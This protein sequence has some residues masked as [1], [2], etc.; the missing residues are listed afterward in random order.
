MGIGQ[1]EHGLY[2]LKPKEQEDPRQLLDLSHIHSIPFLNTI[3]S[4]QNGNNNIAKNKNSP[5]NLDDTSL[6]HKRLGHA[7]LRV[8]KKKG[9]LNNAQL[10]EHVYTV[11]P[12]AKQT[13]ILFSLSNACSIQ[14]FDHIHADVW[15]LHRVST[16]NGRRYFMT[17]VDDY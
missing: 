14:S 4:E 16:H 8:L 2:I 12:V 1:E 10:K 13:G 7:P 5:D 6:R 11:L 3:I 17:L 9:S 15:G